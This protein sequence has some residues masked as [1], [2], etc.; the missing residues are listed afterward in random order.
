MSLLKVSKHTFLATAE[1]AP[2]WCIFGILRPIANPETLKTTVYV[3]FSKSCLWTRTL[4]QNGLNKYPKYPP[5]T[6]RRL[7]REVFGRAFG[8]FFQTILKNMSVSRIC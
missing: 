2:E 6:P 3:Q 8:V 1:S 4:F 7:R 5:W